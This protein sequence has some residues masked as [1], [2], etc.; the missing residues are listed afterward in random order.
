[1]LKILSYLI[2]IVLGV[3]LIILAVA[4]R[5]PVILNLVPEGMMELFPVA[6]Q[7]SV[8]LFLVI[9]LGVLIGL[10][11]GFV[12]E[13]IREYQQRAAAQRSAREVKRLQREVKRLKDQ[14]GEG[15]DEILSLLEQ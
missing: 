13:F 5:Q 6:Y 2:W 7:V 11:I 15:H 10:L 14:L 9:F 1:M 3:A 4:N 8:P 12:W